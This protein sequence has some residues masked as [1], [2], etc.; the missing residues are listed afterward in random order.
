MCIGESLSL[1]RLFLFTSCILQNFTL[2]PA[3]GQPQSFA[4]SFSSEDRASNNSDLLADIGQ[5]HGCAE[6]PKIQKDNDYHS[7]CDP[8]LF[9]FGLISIDEATY[10]VVISTTLYGSNYQE[11]AGRK[12]YLPDHK[13]FWPSQEALKQHR[14]E[15]QLTRNT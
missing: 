3:D 10:R 14:E 9:D 11:Y 12:L 1:E 5:P 13:E 6:P 4:E 8:R 15:A 2:L 7:I